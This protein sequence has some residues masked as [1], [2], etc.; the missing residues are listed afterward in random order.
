MKQINTNRF[1][2]NHSRLS[3][4]L[5]E[6]FVENYSNSPR[7][8]QPEHLQLLL[9][10]NISDTSSTLQD[11]SNKLVTCII[12]EELTRLKSEHKT[13]DGEAMPICITELEQA[14][15]SRVLQKTKETAEDPSSVAKMLESSIKG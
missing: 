11:S 5:Q 1:Y 9:E 12:N 13:A 8:L 4:I 2:S 10:A 7:R 14:T 15:H 6:S 3:S